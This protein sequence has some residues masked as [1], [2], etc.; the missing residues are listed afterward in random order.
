MT[1][2]TPNEAKV[3]MPATSCIG[4]DRYA[5]EVTAVYRYT[6]GA[7]KGQVRAVETTRGLYTLRTSR[8]LNGRLCREGGETTFLRLGVAENY[9]DPHF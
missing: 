8:R 7:R 6:S 2:I 1:T 4:G 3:G 9:M 5:T